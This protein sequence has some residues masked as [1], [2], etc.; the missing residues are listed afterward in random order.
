VLPFSSALS[1]EKVRRAL[2]ACTDALTDGQPSRSPS[3]RD[4]VTAWLR[5]EAPSFW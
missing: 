4:R 5:E 3:S 1:D 2:R